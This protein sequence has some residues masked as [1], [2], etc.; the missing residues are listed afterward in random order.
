ME[1]TRPRSGEPGAGNT[2]GAGGAVRVQVTG[3]SDVP[4]AASAVLVSLVAVNPSAGTFLTAAPFPNTSDVNAGRL[5]TRSNLVLVPLSQGG[6]SVRNNA[7]RADVVAD[8]LG[9]VG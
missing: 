6:F 8:V 7:G 2:L 4:A 1:D 9:W 5:T 3:A